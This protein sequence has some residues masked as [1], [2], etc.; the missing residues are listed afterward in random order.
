MAVQLANEPTTI[1]ADATV[2]VGF[3]PPPLSSAKVKADSKPLR[4]G[5][6]RSRDTFSWYD[7]VL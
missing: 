6:K 5:P 7:T 1:R 2:R 4:E 3:S